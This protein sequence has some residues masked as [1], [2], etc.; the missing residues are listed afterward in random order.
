MVDKPTENVVTETNVP[1]TQE[2]DAAKITEDAAKLAT[3][4]ATADLEEKTAEIAEKAT[5]SAKQAI[6]DQLS[7]KKEK[8]WIPDNYDQIVDK[9]VDKS[10]LEREEETKKMRQESEAK[11]EASAKEKEEK[12]KKWN[13]YWDSQIDTMVK[14]GKIASVD[15]QIQAK[16][17]DKQELTEVEKKDPGIQAREKILKKASELKETNL[18]LVFYKHLSGEIK[19]PAGRPSAPVAGAQRGTT[20]ADKTGYSYE[21]IHGKSTLD[22]LQGK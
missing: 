22:I 13:K 1:K 10:R 20:P 15:E 11:Q 3:E 2:I 7:D 14:E 6:V 17:D 4:R 12:L 16:L 5:A 21:E 19:K 8:K 18:E 9:A